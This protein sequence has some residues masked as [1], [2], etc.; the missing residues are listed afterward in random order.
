MRYPEIGKA[1]SPILTMCEGGTGN[2]TTNDE[3]FQGFH[4]G[5]TKS[6]DG[7]TKDHQSAEYVQE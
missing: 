4:G 1:S 7:T 6:F 5:S 2:P 3:D